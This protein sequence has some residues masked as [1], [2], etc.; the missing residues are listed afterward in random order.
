MKKDIDDEVFEDAIDEPAAV[1][2]D[3]MPPKP[4]TK[5]PRKVRYLKTGKVATVGCRTAEL[6]Y[7]AGRIEYLD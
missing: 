7:Q 1:E 6:L 2:L 4:P 5:S 3:P